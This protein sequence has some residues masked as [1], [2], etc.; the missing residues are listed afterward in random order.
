MYANIR[1]QYLNNDTLVREFRAGWELIGLGT[2]AMTSVA[3]VAGSFT[4]TFVLRHGCYLRTRPSIQ[5]RLTVADVAGAT[6][7]RILTLLACGVA[8]FRFA[9]ERTSALTVIYPASVLRLVQIAAL[10]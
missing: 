5:A 6:L 8:K 9:A 10:R 1:T 7:Q 3:P 2:H 4:S